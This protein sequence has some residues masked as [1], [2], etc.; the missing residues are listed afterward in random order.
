MMNIQPTTYTLSASEIT[1]RRQASLML[2]IFLTLGLVGGLTMDSPFETW[3]LAIGACLCFAALLSLRALVLRTF[4]MY[5]KSSVNLYP[6]RLERTWPGSQLTFPYQEINTINIKRTS[7]GSI[8]D[9]EIVRHTASKTVLD[10]LENFEQFLEQLLHC[11]PQGVKIRQT[12][13]PIDYDH[14]LFYVILG[15]LLG[16]IF[17]S[18]TRLIASLEQSVFRPLSLGFALY[19]IAL[20]LYF[21]VKQPLTER[22]GS[23]TRLADWTCGLVLIAAG[24]GIVLITV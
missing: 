2:V 21:A 6:D 1:R 23:K 4:T 11:A 7:R 10:G 16:L 5:L 19:L 18:A 13:E 22:Y 17:A 12:S 15:L 3:Q 9:I 8:R 14:P 20:G 24:I